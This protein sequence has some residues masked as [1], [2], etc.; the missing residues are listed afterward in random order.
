MT[1]TM[2]TIMIARKRANFKI[3]SPV[4]IN[5]TSFFFI[6]KKQYIDQKNQEVPKSTLRVY[7][8]EPDGAKKQQKE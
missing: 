1:Y 2:G 5:L 3:I 4:T 6:D 7:K 8:R